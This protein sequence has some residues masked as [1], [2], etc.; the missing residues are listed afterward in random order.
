MIRRLQELQLHQECRKSDGEGQAKKEGSLK[1]SP[2]MTH[3]GG[4]VK[5]TAAGCYRLNEN[6]ARMES[7]DTSVVTR[8]PGMGPA[9]GEMMGPEI[10]SAKAR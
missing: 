8:V 5:K 10:S 9:T 7:S 1:G 2:A 3:A 4:L 6:V